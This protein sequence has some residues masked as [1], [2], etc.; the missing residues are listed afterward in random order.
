[1][2]TDAKL[3]EILN[4]IELTRQM[5]SVSWVGQ[6][7]REREMQSLQITHDEL[8]DDHK[9]LQRKQAE[10]LRRLEFEKSEHEELKTEYDTL[11]KLVDEYQFIVAMSTTD[12]TVSRLQARIQEL[13]Q[14]KNKMVEDHHSTLVVAANRI[15]ASERKL[16]E[17]QRP[18]EL[19][20]SLE[21]Q[22]TME[23]EGQDSRGRSTKAKRW[24][25]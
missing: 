5:L 19:E 9:D 21:N 16:D 11:G 18:H 22:G 4:T 3:Q 6:M 8:L 24:V 7:Q 15:G 14:E 10:T 12:T 25:S 2:E 13:E 17:M 20:S 23:G 1:M